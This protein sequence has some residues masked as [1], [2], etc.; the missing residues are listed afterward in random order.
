MNRLTLTFFLAFSISLSAK[1]QAQSTLQ[2]NDEVFQRCQKI[3]FSDELSKATVGKADSNWET[4]QGNQQVQTAEGIPALSFNGNGFTVLKLKSLGESYLRGE[5]TLEFDAQKSNTVN[6]GLDSVLLI[7][8]NNADNKSQ[9]MIGVSSNGAVYYYPDTKFYPDLQAG[10]SSPDVKRDYS[11][12]S[13]PNKNSVWAHVAVSYS[14]MHLRVYIDYVLCL[15]ITNTEMSPAN[16]LIG[17]K[18]SDTHTVSIKNFKLAAHE[19]S[20]EVK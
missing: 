20:D 5:F 8:L 13:K 18:D 1:L 7:Y 10:N 3:I 19:P 17:I 16:F 15:N 11:L 14:E 6:W 2:Q 9:A 4:L 12:F